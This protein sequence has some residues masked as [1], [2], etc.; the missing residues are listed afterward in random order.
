MFRVGEEVTVAEG[1]LLNFLE[2]TKQKILRGTVY[3]YTVY[4]EGIKYTLKIG[5][6]Y[7]NYDEKEVLN[8]G[9]DIE[10]VKEISK[11]MVEKELVKEIDY[12]NRKYFDKGYAKNF[13]F[14][15]IAG[16]DTFSILKYAKMLDVKVRVTVEENHAF[17]EVIRNA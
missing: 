7:R 3:S 2:G 6:E 5:K 11:N 8:S 13:N 1:G 14:A 4:E 12:F 9:I 17:V 10:Q 16:V 15:C